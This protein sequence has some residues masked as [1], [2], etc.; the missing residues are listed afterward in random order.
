MDIQTNFIVPIEGIITVQGKTLLF[1]DGGYYSFDW[2]D[3]IGLNIH[4]SK[5]PRLFFL[6]NNRNTI[7]ATYISMPKLTRQEILEQSLEDSLFR[8]Y[9]IRTDPRLQEQSF[10]EFKKD[11]SKEKNLSSE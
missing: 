2:N 7:N 6:R 8:S 4:T 1:D 5:K 3:K 10:T 9:L 11:R